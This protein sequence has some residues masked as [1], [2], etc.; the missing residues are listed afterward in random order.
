MRLR[1]FWVLLIVTSGLSNSVSAENNPRIYQLSDEWLIYDESYQ[2]FVPY[3][4]GTYTSIHMWI[5]VE[6]FKEYELNFSASEGTSVFVNGKLLKIIETSGPVFLDFKTIASFSSDEKALITFYNPKEELPYDEIWITSKVSLEDIQE[7]GLQI[8]PRKNSRDHTFPFTV[9]IF[10][11]GTVAVLKNAYPKRFKEMT[12][13]RRLIQAY[14]SEEQSAP[15]SLFS[16]TGSLALLFCSGS[17]A[18]IFMIMSKNEV[19]QGYGQLYIFLT[20]GILV[21][22][23]FIL[24]YL[25]INILAGI[26]NLSGLSTVHFQETM[27]AGFLFMLLVLPVFSI[28]KFSNVLDLT[29][30]YIHFF[31]ILLI[32]FS[33]MLLRLMFLIFNSS[34]FRNI[35]LFSYLCVSEILPLLIVLKIILVVQ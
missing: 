8:L 21:F 6:R 23:L 13:F 16:S 30:S 26:F 31:Y 18:L 4:K 24:R 1:L 17:L 7:A 5:N 34:K 20:V 3:I 12:S 27:R 9:F 33:I 14:I 10:F 35:Y 32:F 25:M 29:F 2:S 19:I 22:M 15:F 28:V 11:L